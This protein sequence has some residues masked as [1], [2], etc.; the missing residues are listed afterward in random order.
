MNTKVAVL[1]GGSWGTTLG[2]LLSKKGY[3][4][5]LWEYCKEHVDMLKTYR[6]NIKFLPGIP[7]PK[8]IIITNDIYECIKDTR[9]I[10]IAVP[11]HAV[12]SVVRRFVDKV[13]DDIIIVSGTKGLEED[14]LD[15]PSQ[16]IQSEFSFELDKSIVVLSGP[17]HAEEVSRG[18]PT[19]VVA[20]C[21]HEDNAK[22]IQNLFSTSFFRVYTNTDVIGVELGGALKN[23]IALASGILY[24]LKFGDNTTAALITRGLAEIS[25]LGIA[26][27]ARQET[28]FGLSGIGDLVV[29]CT[30]K[31]SRNRQLGEMIGKG[32][33]FEEAYSSMV[34]V[35]EGVNT[36]KAAFVLSQKLGIE[37]PITKEVHAVLFEG[38]SPRKAVEDLMLRELKPEWY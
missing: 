13:S 8:D 17:S 25:R 2:I 28:F 29:T 37:L 27:G 32:S 5:F 34:M 3:K 10:V 9:I 36:T 24:G 22:F 4:V 30:S 26:M 1:G 20:A 11:S 16:V 15:T 23:V 7:I 12:R 33:T 18:I 6:E 21:K 19:T 14:S 31:Y 38:K 35:A